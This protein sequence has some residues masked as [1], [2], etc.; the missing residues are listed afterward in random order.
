MS[1]QIISVDAAEH[2]VTVTC[3]CGREYHHPTEL[4]ARNQHRTHVEIETAR[5]AL[6][7]DG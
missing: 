3:E 6:K 4:G 2:R 5:D 7:G 1:H